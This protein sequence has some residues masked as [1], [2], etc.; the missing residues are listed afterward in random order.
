MLRHSPAASPS[1]LAEGDDHD[2]SVQ[3][4]EQAREFGVTCRRPQR[5]AVCS[6]P[7]PRPHPAGAG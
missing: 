1:S 5:L 7:Q 2:L 4:R 3:R 6:R